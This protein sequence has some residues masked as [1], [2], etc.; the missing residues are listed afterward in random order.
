MRFCFIVEEEY[1][2]DEMP[3]AV[4]ECIRA[5]GHDVDYLE[6]HSSVTRLSD[7]AS[8]STREYDAFVLKTAPDGPGLVLLEAAAAA[9]IPTIN[10]WRSIRLSRDKAVAAALA[11]VH[12]LV[13]P[14]T[15]F[16]SRPNL[17]G[18]IASDHYPLVVKPVQGG[19]GRAVYRIDSPTE[20][21]GLQLNPDQR[22]VGQSYV[23]NPGFDL[24]L[25]NTGRE[26]FAV[27]SPS[28]LH[29]AVAVTP[30]LLPMTPDLRDIVL[31][32][33]VVFGLTIYGVDLV[34][35]GDRWVAVDV[36]DFP[37]FGQVPDAVARLADSVVRRARRMRRS[38]GIRRNLLYTFWDRSAS[39]PDT[40]GTLAKAALVHDDE[41]GVPLETVTEAASARS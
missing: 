32:F 9:G 24:K 5:Q 3:R 16:A 33:G 19:A 39:G 13:M 40:N 17:L 11:Q 35:A 8:G 41:V 4:A 38:H 21:S 30:H 10:S 2:D 37:S 12:G 14:D 23:D 26:I 25:Y 29:P 6:P 20:L 7:L 15:F 18:L 31:A 28:P 1:E 36:N 22:F 27:E 34:R